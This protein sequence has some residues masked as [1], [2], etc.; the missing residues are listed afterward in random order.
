M[1][2]ILIHIITAAMCITAI[3]C[4]SGCGKNSDAPENKSSSPQHE[5]EEEIENIRAQYAGNQMETAD[6]YDI[7]PKNEVQDTEPDS[8]KTT[9]LVPD[10][11]I[12]EGVPTLSQLP[13]FP[14]GCE[15]ISACILLQYN[16]YDISPDTFIDEYL[17]KSDDFYHNDGVCWGPDPYEYF[18]GDPRTNSSYGCMSPVIKNAINKI[19][20]RDD[21]GGI[22]DCDSLNELCRTYI[23]RDIPVM[24]WVSMQME[25]PTP[26]SIWKLPDNSDY[27]WLA[28]E[29]CMVLVGYD[30]THYY[31]NDPITGNTE[32]FEK[33]I[34]ER[35][36]AAFEYQSIVILPE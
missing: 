14:T 30:N 35:R 5:L 1:K 34:S 15:S 6:I 11:Y 36:F 17:H 22:T 4:I 7:I 25:T 29:H 18:I 2:K 33:E 27:Q 9:I 24:V 32:K 3:L 19:L 31:F 21:W 26:G 12:I 28:N 10:T 8:G 20:G 16:G 13:D 23:S